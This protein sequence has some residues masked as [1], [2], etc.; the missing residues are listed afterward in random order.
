MHGPLYA[1]SNPSTYIHP[2]IIQKQILDK[3]RPRTE[4][5]L[6]INKRS[7]IYNNKAQEK[8]RPDFNRGDIDLYNN[9]D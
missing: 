1:V 7:M 9:W 3:G 2:S 8:E 4:E 6:K 5:R